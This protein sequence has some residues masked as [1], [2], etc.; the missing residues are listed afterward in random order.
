[1]LVHAGLVGALLLYC[2]LMR[3]GMSRRGRLLRTGR[4]EG[5]P[6]QKAARAFLLPIVATDEASVCLASLVLSY[7]EVKQGQN[8]KGCTTFNSWGGI[9][10]ARAMGVKAECGKW[11]PI[12]QNAS[13][14]ATQ[15]Q[16]EEFR[17]SL[18]WSR[19]RVRTLSSSL[20]FCVGPHGKARRA[21]HRHF[22]PHRFGCWGLQRVNS[23]KCF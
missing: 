19:G 2:S 4:W 11:G 15:R 14:R 23:K 8:A 10:L 5:G 9:S 18:K 12:F 1:M 13:Q 6:G 17:G 22:V 20:G 7:L 16:E 3:M 21:C